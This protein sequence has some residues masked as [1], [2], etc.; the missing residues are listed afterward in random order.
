MSRAP[1]AERG[2]AAGGRK[3]RA[4][5]PGHRGRRAGLRA[6]A[7]TPNVASAPQTFFY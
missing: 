2:Q 1:A 4:P 5:E 6:K 3:P 7:G